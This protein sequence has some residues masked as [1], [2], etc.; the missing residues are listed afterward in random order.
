MK[1]AMLDQMRPF[2]PLQ[3]MEYI[4]SL[5]AGL[6]ANDDRDAGALLYIEISAIEKV[7]SPDPS[8]HR[9]IL[10]DTSP[11]TLKAI[12]EVLFNLRY[13]FL[14][15]KEIHPIV[16]FTKDSFVD[17]LDNSDQYLTKSSIHIDIFTHTHYL[18]TSPNKALSCILG[19]IDEETARELSKDG[20]FEDELLVANS[21]EIVAKI[22]LKN[23]IHNL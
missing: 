6:N 18:L 23:K 15:D 20:L 21:R 8:I 4:Q 11:F 13:C 3:Y 22:K 9:D 7:M 12:H 1:L 2:Y 14:S 17:F 5:I 19:V 16:F 10:N